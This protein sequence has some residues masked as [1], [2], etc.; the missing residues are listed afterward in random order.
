[1]R[2]SC[3]SKS[4]SDPKQRPSCGG[5]VQIGSLNGVLFNTM[6]TVS[7][8]ELQDAVD[9]VSSDSMDDGAYVCRQTG[10][11][12]WISS[13]PGL[14]DEEDTVPDDV[15][16]VGKYAPV[17][18]RRDLDLGSRL[19]FRFAAQ[20]LADQYDEVR[21]TFRHKGA[22]GRFKEILHRQDSLEIW[23]AYSEERTMKALE[24][25]CESE[26]LGIER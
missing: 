15:H 4:T 10:K 14:L 17:P 11:I 22:Y 25:W 20:F 19:V 2:W 7:L 26:G 8:D 1:M 6:P 3:P 23:Y 12:Y 24:I 5:R 18:D 13:E 9:W 21:N 16:D